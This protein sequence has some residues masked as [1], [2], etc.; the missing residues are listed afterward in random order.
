MQEEE[1]TKLKYVI[2]QLQVTGAGNNSATTVDIPAP[3][4]TCDTSGISMNTTRSNPDNPVIVNDVS[5]REESSDSEAF[6]QYQPRCRRKLTK[7]TKRQRK[8]NTI[9]SATSGGGIR[10]VKGKTNTTTTDMY[11]R[12][13][14]SSH[15]T[16]DVTERIHNMVIVIRYPVQVLSCKDS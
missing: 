15:S 4:T 6:F 1:N 10:S 8:R 12:G 7:L 2:I 11:I 13:V 16:S 9:S 3:T 5:F 14:H